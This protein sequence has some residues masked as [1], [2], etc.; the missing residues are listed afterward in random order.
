MDASPQV[1]PS[2]GGSGKPSA[3]AFPMEHGHLKV[4]VGLRTSRSYDLLPES[5]AKEGA[6][7]DKSGTSPPASFNSLPHTSSPRYVYTYM[8]D[9]SAQCTLLE[10]DFSSLVEGIH[11]SKGL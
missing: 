4:G 8:Y 6:K 11:C 7:Q 9:T 5:A 3:E 10:I 2:P 1:V